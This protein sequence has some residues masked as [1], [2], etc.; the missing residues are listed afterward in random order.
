MNKINKILNNKNTKILIPIIVLIVIVIVLIIYFKEYKYNNYRNKV[1][2]E[3]YQ[4]LSGQKMEYT[5][6]VAFNK[7]NEIK[8]FNPK[9]LN[10][11]YGSIPIYYKNYKKVIFPNEMSIIFPIKSKSQFKLEEFSY[12]E[13][14]NNIYYLTNSY[15]HKNI[16]HFIIYDGDGLYLF[17]DEVSFNILGNTINLSPMSY[18]ISRKNSFSYYDYEKDIYNSYET[19]N[20]I[21]LSNDYYK[22]NVSE[23][24]IEYQDDKMLLT[25]DLDFLTLLKE[26]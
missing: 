11:N 23:D 6:S 20:S 8:E 24:F 26:E 12:I 25:N 5:S 4:Y 2:E 9:N 22:V 7:N 15:Y 17:S 14:V 16:D 21:V 3:F 10:I 19:D 13:K 1:E 18:V